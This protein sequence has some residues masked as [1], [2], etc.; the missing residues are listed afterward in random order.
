MRVRAKHVSTRRLPDERLG[1]L[2]MARMAAGTASDSPLVTLDMN[3]KRP[4]VG[5]GAPAATYYPEIARRL[6]A[7][8]Y[9]S[10]HID[11][12]P[13]PEARGA[14]VYSLSDVASDAETAR[15]AERENKA[16]EGLSSEQDG[17]VRGMLSDLTL[18]E[19]MI[20]SAT[21]A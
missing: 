2:V 3:L 19:Q 4:L 12:A 1:E 14:T 20:S 11:S 17:S 18:R 16:G 8:A 21:L 13:N 5:I 6:G 15:F 10:L 9:L 7:S